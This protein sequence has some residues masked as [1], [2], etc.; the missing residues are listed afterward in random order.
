MT[1]QCQTTTT[2]RVS[3]SVSAW[4]FCQRR[5][6]GSAYARTP[7]A[8]RTGLRAEARREVK[9][10]WTKRGDA[11]AEKWAHLLT[12]Q[13]VAS[14]LAGRSAERAANQDDA[15]RQM[16]GG[17]IGAGDARARLSPNVRLDAATTA[18]IDWGESSRTSRWGAEEKKNQ[19]RLRNLPEY[20]AQMPEEAAALAE[21]GAPHVFH[22]KLRLGGNPAE[23]LARLKQVV[24]VEARIAAAR[25]AKAAAEEAASDGR[26]KR[27]KMPNTRFAEG[28][29]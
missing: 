25:A 22:G 2:Q 29:T 28:S 15:T 5:S 9:V 23:V 17:L 26:G 27:R 1:S 19:L 24:A 3:L 12:K 7:T 14:V 18:T 6:S 21:L 10:E 13:H 16:P 8:S 4:T 11:A 20:A